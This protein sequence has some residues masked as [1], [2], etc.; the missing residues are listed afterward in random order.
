VRILLQA[1]PAEDLYGEF[2]TLS[3]GFVAVGTRSRLRPLTRHSTGAWLRAE[4]T[5]SSRPG[6][7]GG[8]ADEGLLVQDAGQG[9]RWLP[10]QRLGAYLRALQAE[11]AERLLLLSQPLEEAAGHAE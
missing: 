10:R 11:D 3:E 2:S 9:Q 5:G 7:E 1:A 8:F 4:Q 6:G